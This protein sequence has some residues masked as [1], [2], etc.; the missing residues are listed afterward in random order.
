MIKLG[1]LSDTHGNSPA[2]DAALKLIGPVDGYLH[3]GDVVT[4]ADRIA[5]V[6]GKPVYSV[7]GNCDSI[8]GP[9]AERPTEL[10]VEFEG[11]KLLLVHGHKHGIDAYSTFTARERAI[12]LGCSALVYGHTHIPQL[13]QRDGIIVLNPGSPS[14]PR[15]GYKPSCAVIEIENGKLRGRILTL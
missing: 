13:V 12:E 14:I 1:V 11:V 10:A 8:L 7:R 9:A 5:S 15:G 2:A 4:D 3:L 6:T